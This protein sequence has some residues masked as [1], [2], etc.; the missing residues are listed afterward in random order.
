VS[1][2]LSFARETG[3]RERGVKMSMQSLNQL[4]ARSIIDPGVVQAFAAGQI[5]EV[6]SDLDF[7]PEMRARLAGLKAETWAEY[8][9]LAYRVVR[10]AAQPVARIQLPSPAEGLLPDEARVSKRRVA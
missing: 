10:A 2:C 3:Y 7:S 6:L 8:A 4:V 1:R 9:V 5:G